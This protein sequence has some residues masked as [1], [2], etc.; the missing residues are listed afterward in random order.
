MRN[1]TSPALVTARIMWLPALLR[2]LALACAI[3]SVLGVVA[4]FAFET[5]YPYRWYLLIGG[6]IG[7]ALFGWLGDKVSPTRETVAAVRSE[8]LREDALR[9]DRKE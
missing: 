9:A 7:S 3:A 6:S 5:L 2:L 4:F 8:L 1:G